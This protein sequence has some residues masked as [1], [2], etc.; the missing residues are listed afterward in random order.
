MKQMTFDWR[1]LLFTFGICILTCLLFGLVP[2]LKVSHVELNTTLKE[3]GGRS[4]SAG[5][6]QRIR[7]TLLASEVEL[8]VLLSVGAGLLMRSF[9]RVMSVNPGLRTENILTMNISLPEV[10]Y[11]TPQ[12]RL[13]FF[14]TL[15]E[16]LQASPGVRSGAT[17]FLP[18]SMS[19]LSVRIGV[20]GFQIQ[21]HPALPDI[22]SV[23][24]EPGTEAIT[25][26]GDMRVLRD[27]GGGPY[28]AK[29]IL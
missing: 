24:S 8:A 12:Q 14:K 4:D 20:S 28:A 5:G 22:L 1:A 18:I 25:V 27:R 29:A 7:G 23:G 13:T 21:G 26:G 10:K 11:P 9:V 19:I 15:M 16:R 6:S 17:Q 2:A 3:A